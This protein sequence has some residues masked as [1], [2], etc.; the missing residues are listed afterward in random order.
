VTDE[1]PNQPL[2]FDAEFLVKRGG[3]SEKRSRGRHVSGNGSR[4]A[5]GAPGYLSVRRAAEMLGLRPRSVIYLLAVGR[6]TS[7]R[8]GR[9]H[10]LPVAEVDR[11]RRVRRDRAARAAR[12]RPRNR[13]IKLIR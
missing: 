12:N 4:I 3:R 1:D 9:W 10:F 6:L 7:Q 8:L 5:V 11:Y 13:G 2:P